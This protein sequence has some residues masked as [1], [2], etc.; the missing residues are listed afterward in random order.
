MARKTV[1]VGN[2]KM[3]KTPAEAKKF[4]KEFK[5]L[6]QKNKD[7]I[8]NT[9]F[10]I[11]APS[12]DLSI[13]KE[14]KVIPSMIVAAEDVRAEASGAFT[15][16][17]S[18]AMVK[19]VGANAVVVGHSER[20]EYHHET[21]K[22]INAKIK[23]IFENKMLPIFCIGETLDLRKNK[24]WKAHLT[25]QIKGG[26][27]TLTEE[28]VS[29]LIIAYEPIWAIG[30]GVTAS[31]QEAEEACKHVRNV[32]AKTT[33]AKAAEKVIIQYGGSVK[34]Q[35]IVELLAKPN[36]DGAL[37]GGASLEAKSYIKLLTLNK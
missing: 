8:K 6:Y 22:D 14:T 29:K 24:K 35:N 12:V 21:D 15:G 4:M 17:L 32:V 26:L 16:D 27:K 13:L 33:S 9:K 25:K 19:T 34:P 18:A 2:W 10:G 3:N 23:T 7:K 37:V 11:A 20:R 36:I 5:T 1:I 28:H 30:T 31:A